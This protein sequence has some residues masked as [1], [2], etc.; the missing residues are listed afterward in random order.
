MRSIKSW[1][2]SLPQVLMIGLY[3]FSLVLA[4]G[5]STLEKRPSGPVVSTSDVAIRDEQ[6]PGLNLKLLT[7]QWR[8]LEQSDQLIITG[9]AQNLT[10]EHL[11][12]CRILVTAYDQFDHNLGSQETYLT[13]TVLAPEQRGQF[14]F[15]LHYGDWVKAIK[16]IYR[17]EKRY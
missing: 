4:G 12:G 14:S 5:C 9:W 15:Y 13:P 17:F 3:F 10:G 7:F 2:C 1:G 11:Q 6:P 16:L 8:Y